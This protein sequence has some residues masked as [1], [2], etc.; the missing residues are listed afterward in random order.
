[1]S[2]KNAK[3]QVTHDQKTLAQDN[4]SLFQNSGHFPIHICLHIHI[5]KY[6]H[7]YIHTHISNLFNTTTHVYIAM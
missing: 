1:M 7:K 4:I 2:K 3:S 5:H 6:I